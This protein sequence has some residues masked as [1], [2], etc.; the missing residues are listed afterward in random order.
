MKKLYSALMTAFNEDGSV[1]EAGIREM[2]RYNIDVNKVDGLYVGGSTGE[3]FNMSHDQKVQVFKTAIDEAGDAIDLI[4]QV[5]SLDLNESKELAKLVTDLGY[6]KISAVTPFYYNYT[7]EQI[8]NYYNEIVKDV[9]NKLVIYSIPVLTGVSLSIDQF[10]ELFENPKIIGIKYTNADFFLLERVRNRFPDKL[11]LSG[12]DEM[13][14]P[15]LALNVDGAI[16]STYNLN[17][18]RAKAEMVAFD[19]GDIDKARELQKVS[20]DAISALIANDIYPSLK[21]VF[22]EMGV[23]AGVTKA[24]MSK[25][26]PEMIAGAKKIYND[27]FKD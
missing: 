19:E 18:K 7:F 21:L 11:I 20:N 15:A 2:V 14:L 27:Y 8:K 17:A 23:H 5:G 22:E 3:N 1:N 10:A 9:D 4:A 26:T 24:P 16:G 6:P 25:P 13:L 12:F